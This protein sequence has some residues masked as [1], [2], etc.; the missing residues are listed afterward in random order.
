MTSGP[1][2]RPL[3]APIAP[4]DDHSPHTLRLR[5]KPKGSLTGYVDGGWW[6][7]SRELAVELPALVTVLAVRLGGVRHVDFVTAEWDAA[8][9]RITVD[10]H[11]VR[12]EGFRSEDEHIVHV[13]GADQRITLLVIPHGAT[14]SSSHAAMM[15][16]ARRD[17]GE[18][19]VDI[20]TA[21]G[22][23]PYAPPPLRLVR[24]DE[25]A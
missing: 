10:G 21:A 19:P 12:L 23:T 13:F 9:P 11:P 15:R 22:A 4:L 20:L 2:I 25:R 14:E 8:P 5:L 24:D 1:H 7:R 3:P 6:P 18:E 17:N 16:A